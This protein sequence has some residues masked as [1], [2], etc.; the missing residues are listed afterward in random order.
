MDG[1]IAWGSEDYFHQI[2]YADQFQEP[3]SRTDFEDG[4]VENTEVDLGSINNI[5]ISLMVGVSDKTVTPG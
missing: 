1:P 2:A 4:A 3:L 5:S